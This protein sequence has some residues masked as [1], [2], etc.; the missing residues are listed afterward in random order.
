MTPQALDRIRTYGRALASRWAEHAAGTPHSSAFWQ[1]E[2][3]M[4]RHLLAGVEAL[5]ESGAADQA[6]PF[7]QFAGRL[8]QEAFAREVPLDEVMRVL[9]GIKPIVLETLTEHPSAPALD[10]STIESLNR[11]LSLG[12]L[13][14]I[15]RYERQRDR[16]T[17]AVQE[18]IEEL[19]GRLRHH[20]LVDPVT[21]MFNANAFALAAHR[22]VLRSRRFGRTFTIALVALD[23]AD[24]IC[25]AA[26]EE[27]LRAV[28]MQIAD[29]LTRSTRQVDFRATLGGGRFGVILPETATDGAFV[30]A[31]RL[32]AAV[33]QA[34]VAVPDHPYPITH[35]VSI[36]L[37]CFPHDGEDD[38]TLLQRA[39]E[40]LARAGSGRN[41]TA[42][43]ATAQDF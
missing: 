35:T 27:G 8:S 31:E 7:V 28:T 10:V 23:Q 2:A 11:L 5:V 19:R 42:A 22:E 38:Q 34:T 13:E 24:E 26:G 9:L 36:G 39:E 17:L 15:R 1:D 37:A 29:M 6:D 32:R 21:G 25:E 16:R 3:R 43:A 30:V 41:A 20:V 12:V 40:A 14:V 18:Q 4:N 33:E